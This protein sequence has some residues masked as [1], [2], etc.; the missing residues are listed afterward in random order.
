MHAKKNKVILIINL[1]CTFPRQRENRTWAR[2]AVLP[3]NA[4]SK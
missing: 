2:S 1:Y 3:I 4:N